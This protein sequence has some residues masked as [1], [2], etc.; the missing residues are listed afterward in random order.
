MR[1]YIYSRA[2]IPLIA[3]AGMILF[4]VAVDHA[5]VSFLSG[6]FLSLGISLMLLHIYLL[7]RHVVSPHCSAEAA[8]KWKHAIVTIGAF[9]FG[10]CLA[11]VAGY[12]EIR[13]SSSLDVL[14]DVTYIEAELERPSSIYSNFTLL[15]LVVHRATVDEISFSSQSRISCFYNER[16]LLA[17]ATKIGAEVRIRFDDTEDEIRCTILDIVIDEEIRAIAYRIDRV[18]SFIARAIRD[19][20]A[21]FPRSSVPLLHALFLGE[22]VDLHPTL[23]DRFRTAGV[24]HLLALSG[25][26]LAILTVFSTRLLRLV[27]P[28]R[29][30]RI[31]N[32]VLIILYVWIV[33]SKPSLNRAAVMLVLW[34][35][36]HLCNREI[37]TINLLAYACIILLFIDGSVRNALSFQLSFAALAGIILGSEVVAERMQFLLPRIVS[38]PLAAATVAQAS[39]LPLLLYHFGV[40]YPI[41]IIGSL[42][43][44]PLVA[45]FMWSALLL[46]PLQYLPL[47]ILQ[48]LMDRYMII[49][50]ALINRGIDI[51]SQFPAYQW[52]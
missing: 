34:N 19:E 3:A 38:Q 33:G 26:H 9:F 27:L 51:F 45:L 2:Y 22:R 23:I 16:I 25:M 13:E 8:L 12:R 41:G 43:L 18:R 39:T 50:Y 46:L 14:A 49:I 6:Y 11:A 35:V 20:F 52:Q 10:V 29:A 1:G 28:L 15:S 47:T 48:L 44:T 32:I 4:F 7:F 30:V 37:S 21:L 5:N 17:T 31:V 40:L 24:S 42:A 36:M